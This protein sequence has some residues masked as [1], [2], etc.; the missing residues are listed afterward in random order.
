MKEKNWKPDKKQKNEKKGI[1]ISRKKTSVVTEKAM[2]V[3]SVA[4]VTYVGSNIWRTRHIIEKMPKASRL[5]T[6]ELTACLLA[7][8]WWR[9]A[10]TALSTWNDQPA[11]HWWRYRRN[12]VKV[13]A[14][15]SLIFSASCHGKKKL[16]DARRINLLK[17]ADGV[18]W[19]RREMWYSCNHWNSIGLRGV[20]MR[21]F[22]SNMWQ[23]HKWK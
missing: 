9:P 20:G 14:V 11:C 7:K 12:D 6:E 21:I 13:L 3:V 10:C 22:S 1:P 18:T 8:S 2:K 5:T 17:I 23:K 4:Y 16:F 15:S 19:R